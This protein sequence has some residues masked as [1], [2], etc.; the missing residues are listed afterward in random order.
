CGCYTYPEGA[1]GKATIALD[2]GQISLSDSSWIS[3]T[4][5]DSEYNQGGEATVTLTTTGTG[6]VTIQSDSSIGAQGGHGLGYGSYTAY[7]DD[8]SEF[9]A[10][11]S[12]GGKASVTL[13]GGSGPILLDNAP[14]HAQG[15]DGGDG[16]EGKGNGGAAKVKLTTLDGGISVNAREI[17]A[18]GGYGYGNQSYFDYA[19]DRYVYPGAG[20]KAEI[21]LDGGAGSLSLLGGASLSAEGGDSDYYNGGAAKVKLAASG[22]ITLDDGSSVEAHGG[23]GYSYGGYYI[24]NDYDEGWFDLGDGGKATVKLSAGGG[25]SVSGGSGMGADGG[26]GNGSDSYY[27][28]DGNLVFSGTGG[29]ARVE[30]DGGMGTILLDGASILAGGGYSS[31]YSGGSAKVSLTTAA[32]VALQSGS[33]I[34]AVGGDG[35]NDGDTENFPDAGAAEISLKGEAGVTLGSVEENA[36]LEATGG[37]GEEG[38]GTARVEAV[39]TSGDIALDGYVYSRGDAATSRVV[40]AAAGNFLNGYGAEAIDADGR[41]LVYS[42]NP[43]HNVFN[44]LYSGEQALW[45]ATYDSAPPDSITEAGNRYLFAFQ[46]VLTFDSGDLS[47]TYGADNTAAVAALSSTGTSGLVDADTLDSGGAP[48][49]NAFVQDTLETV[50]SG[51]VSFT[52]EGAGALHGVGAYAIAPDG[53]TSLTGYAFGNSGSLAVEQALLSASL[54]GTASRTYDGTLTATL[55]SGNFL[56]AGFV[57]GDSASVTK[58]TGTYADKNVGSDIEVNVSLASSDFSPAGSTSLSNYFLPTGA[59]GNIGVID[60]AALTVTAPTVTKTYDGTTS[61]S[62]T[63]AVGSLAGA[64]AGEAVNTAAS[65]AYTDKNA[66]TDKTVK[67][68]GLT[69]KDSDSADVTANYDISYVDNIASVINKAALTVT[70]PT[71]TKTYDGTTSASGTAAVG[72]LAG[73]AAGEAVNTAASLA[74]ADKNA[75]T[76]KTVKASG[77]TIK[78]SDSADV[79]AN[80][81]ISYVDNIASVINQRPLSIWKGGTSGNWSVASNWDALPDLSN[82]LAVTAPTGTTVTY[83]AA[84]GTTNLSTLTAGGLAITGGTL[85]IADSLTVSSSFNQSGGTLGDFAAGSSASITQASGNLILPKITVADLSLNAPAGAITQ[86][87][88]LAV[89]TLKTSS[90][91]ATTLTNPDN[92]ISERVDMKAGGPIK[93]WA[94]GDLALG[95]IDAGANEVEI[96]AGGAILQAAGTE[97]ATNVIASLANLTSVFGGASGGLAI[98]TNTQLSGALTATVGAEA[99]FGGIRIQNT[100]AAPATL[101]LVDNALAGAS[102]SFLNTGNITSTAG[103]TLQTLTGGDL[104]L[105]SNGNITWDG[106]TLATPS[107]SAL[108]SADGTLDVTGALSSPVDLALSSGSAINV[109]GSGSVRTQ[110]TGTASFTASS[111]VINGSVDAADDV[112]IIADTINFGA[113]SSTHAGHD[114]IF[115]A[116][117]VLAT[118]ASVEADHDISGAVTGDLRLNGSSFTAGNDIIVNMLGALSTLYLNDVAGLPQS[119]LWAKA[120]STIHLDYA[121]RTSGG[122]VV[123]G[124]AVDPS[125]YVTKAGGSGLYYGAAK[126]PA[127]IGAGL[128]LTYADG[129]VA[130]GG[131]SGSGAEPTVIDAVLAAI[132]AITPATQTTGLAPASTPDLNDLPAT[133]AGPGADETGGDEGTFGA[134]GDEEDENQ[135]D[136]QTGLKKKSKNGPRRSS[137]PA[138]NRRHDHASIRTHPGRAAP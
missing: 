23:Q 58:T 53:I 73:A 95:V 75:G 63:A 133:G 24:D 28:P 80:Y 6:G 29:A 2:G 92:Q 111:V 107:G 119:F 106:G 3:A 34:N 41:W 136:A 62:G 126:N 83:N 45:N 33:Y 70:A 76:D 59:S 21:K 49:S 39:S 103:Y 121:A 88:P 61:A 138:A 32:T 19:N 31:D 124:V 97:A 127:S 99:D 137:R 71:V 102:V 26:E 87:G 89:L 117:N 50:Y 44:G 5:G 69:I 72:S 128:E 20:G 98:S 47:K 112:G 77:L 18:S 55:T 116:A 91:G 118:N 54:T 79:T 1:G 135:T 17:D 66:G 12:H 38:Q 35:W 42:E 37:S 113:G 46:P 8:D 52:S 110:G 68:S 122:L 132:N 82:V 67:A 64:A 78:D 36:T 130:P 109:N 13:D 15:G 22:T 4:G 7:Y 60:K 10:Y 11:L 25:I 85:N 93:L 30:L 108:I 43:A 96:K 114:V 65:L 104:G 84:A 105:L 86:S 57:N 131:G 9:D 120:P 123:D 16:G 90:Q 48:Y 56:L 27:D 74:Y 40:L 14:I 134:N 100:G 81:D 101:T 115:G 51:T 94:S 129:T 125:T